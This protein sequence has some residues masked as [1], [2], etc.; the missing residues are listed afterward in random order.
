[1]SKDRQNLKKTWLIVAG[2][3]LIIV[4]IVA[5]ILFL[6]QGETTT[7]GNYPGSQT[8]NTLSCENNSLRYPVFKDES[9]GNIKINMIFENGKAS[10]ITLISTNSYETAE[11]AK[12]SSDAHHA[13]M[14]IDFGSLGADA[15]NARY[16]VDGTK[17]QMS[18]HATGKELKGST[19]KYFLIKG[20]PTSPETYMKNYTDQHF[21][22]TENN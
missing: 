19:Y 21:S 12:I 5:L 18:L 4:A 3:I 11:Q 9:V 13:D 22:C 20:T 17:T 7:S 1:M 8:T 6:L 2:I 16:M 15:L 10:S 14:N